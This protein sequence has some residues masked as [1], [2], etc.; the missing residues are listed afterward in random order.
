MVLQRKLLYM[1]LGGFL[2][3]ALTFGAFAAF[4]Q[5]DEGVDAATPEAETETVPDVETDNSGTLTNPHSLRPDR[6]DVAG[7]TLSS[8]DELLADALGITVDE[9]QVAKDAVST[10]VIEQA[11]ADGT[12]TQDEADQLL[13]D[14]NSYHS[15]HG[16]GISGA[17][18]DALLADAL[19]I[20]V[21]ELDAAQA[22]VYSAR[23]AEMVEAG[24][25]TQEQAD[26]MQAYKNVEGYIDYDAL[27]ESVQSFY[28]AAIEQALADGVITQEQADLMTSNLADMGVRGFASPD[29]GPGGHG[30][31]G[32]GGHGRPGGFE[33]FDGSSAPVPQA[34]TDTSGA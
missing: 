31:H 33:G 26:Q 20:S 16:F 13:A 17:D 2:A 18:Q 34:P 22:E 3:L 1:V 29:F 19:G 11:V 12:I 28:Q 7:S 23:L 8:D 30:S 9:L 10:A 25:L 4:A 24:R 15:R 32:H 21:E 5:T 14:S 27:N 6:S